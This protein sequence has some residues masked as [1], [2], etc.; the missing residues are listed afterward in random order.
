MIASNMT[1]H[2]IKF[3][4][5]M[6]IG[7]L[8]NPMNML[9]YRLSD[10]YF[11]RTLFYGGILMASHMV[12]AHEIIHY[13]TM[14]HFNMKIFGIGVFLSLLTTFFL[15]KQIFVDDEQWLRRMISHHST[16]LTTTHNIYKQTHNEKLKKLANDIITTQEK[17]IALM[18]SLLKS[19]HQK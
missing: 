16:A 3:A 18:K 19:R 8:L 12:W 9:A 4:M 5:M 17:E 10:L 14:G 7:I 15:R 1:N 11:S 2:F 13:L 6:A